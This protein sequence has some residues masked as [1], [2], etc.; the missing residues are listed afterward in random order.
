M[1]GLLEGKRETLLRL[2]VRAGVDV[3]DESHSHIAAC[4]DV[5]ALGRWCENVLGAKNIDEVLQ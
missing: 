2:L 1:S 3:A 5:T 4:G